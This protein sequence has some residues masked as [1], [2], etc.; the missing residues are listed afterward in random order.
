MNGHSA[1]TCIRLGC[2]DGRFLSRHHVCECEPQGGEVGTGA[3]EGATGQDTGTAWVT[4]SVDCPEAPAQAH[5]LAATDLPGVA[6]FDHRWVGV[7]RDCM[8]CDV[9]PPR[10]ASDSSRVALEVLAQLSGRSTDG[11]LRDAIAL[12]RSALWDEVEP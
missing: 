7:V 10:K 11:R 3:G 6:C 9:D 8:R 4:R 1:E 2:H 12:V 5:P